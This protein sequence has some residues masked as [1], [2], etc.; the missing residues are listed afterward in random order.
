MSVVGCSGSGKTTL[1]SALARLLGAPHIELDAIFHQPG[2][3]ELPRDEFRHRVD[4]A[5]SSKS[6]VVDGNYSSVRD[7]IWPKADVVV[8][9]DLPYATVVSRTV[10]R[11]VR[12][13][14]TRE[15]LWNGN[16]EPFSN[17]WSFDPQRSIIAWTVTQHSRYGRQMR[18][19]AADPRWSGLEF[20]RLGSQ[21]EAD[22]YLAGVAA[23]VGKEE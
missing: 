14:I 1:A 7:V 12:R 19:A 6:W 18:E 22:G 21:A 2:W 23:G 15:E 16:K 17:L 20:V 11:T 5:T 3:T 10:R 9:F 4:Q 8:W 13:V